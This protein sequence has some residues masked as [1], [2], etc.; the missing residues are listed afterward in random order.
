MCVVWPAPYPI[1]Y[2][3]LL[4]LHCTALHPPPGKQQAHDFTSPNFGESRG[5]EPL[6]VK[7]GGGEVGPLVNPS[8]PYL[9]V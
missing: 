2:T 6:R 3:T 5:S 9:S 1:L 8:T 4:A 7:S